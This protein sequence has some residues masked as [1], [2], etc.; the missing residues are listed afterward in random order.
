[1]EKKKKLFIY[2]HQSV[3]KGGVEK[4]FYNLFNNLPGDKFEITVLNYVAYLTNDL[5]TISYKGQKRRVWFYYDE[6]SP[7]TVR[8]FLQRIH[9]KLMPVLIPVWLKFQ[10]FDVAIAAQ[11]GMC[12]RFVDERVRAEKKFLWIHNDLHHLRFNKAPFGGSA[13]KEAECYSHYNKVI[14][15]S[16]DVKKSVL[17]C[18]GELNNLCVCYNPID[19]REIDVALRESMPQRPLETLFV[20]VGRLASQKGYDRLLRVCVKL[21]QEGWR[22]QVWS[23]GEGSDRSALEAFIHEYKI[24]NVTLFG[25]QVNPFKYIKQ[26]DWLLCTSR[27]EGFNM[28][29]Q[30]ATYCEVPIMTT[31]NAG[32][33]E[34]LG[35]SEYGMIVDNNDTAIEQGMRDVLQDPALHEK[36]AIAIK[37]RKSFVCLDNRIKEI[38]NVLMS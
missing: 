12:A 38:E 33:E 8:R 32:T 7:K 16:Q 25:N 2:I 10:H 26:A 36:Y 23:I 4:V 35:N 22:Y 3:L 6:F 28:V 14:C 31:R 13:E 20:C 29:L 19:T 17:E 24:H 11:E 21:N 37:Q 18:V 27:H 1:M 34:L 15:V 30:E 9:N 5:G